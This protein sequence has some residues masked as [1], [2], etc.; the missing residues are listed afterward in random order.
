LV[1][2]AEEDGEDSDDSQ[3][4]GDSDSDSD[5]DQNE[6]NRGMP[7][8]LPTATEKFFADL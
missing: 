4:S 7:R 6:A 2:E 8:R 5:N 1:D 3:M